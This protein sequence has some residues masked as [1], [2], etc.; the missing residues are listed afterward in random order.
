MEKHFGVGGSDLRLLAPPPSGSQE[1]R[2]EAGLNSGRLEAAVQ[3]VGAD[4]GAAIV[5]RTGA[6]D[7][8]PAMVFGSERVTGLPDFC[9]IRVHQRTP[10]GHVVETVV[11]VPEAWNGRLIAAGGGGNRTAA[12]WQLPSP[13]LR[14]IS[15]A[16]AL[17][18]GFAVATTDAGNRDARLWDWGLDEGS[19]ELDEELIE[20]WA[21]RSTH[22]LAVIAKLVVE[23]LHGAPPKYS[24]FIGSS[25]GGRQ[26][27][28]EAQRFPKDFDGIWAADP[29][30]KWSRFQPVGIW[31]AIVMNDLGTPVPA[32]KQ[33]AFRDAAVSEM[34]GPDNPLGAFIAKIDPVRWD[35]RTLI[36][37][38]TPAGRI[39]ER[40]AEVM[41]KLWEGPADRNGLRLYSGLRPGGRTWGTAMGAELSATAEVD[42][43]LRPILNP[44]TA[45]YLSSWV[46]RDPAWRW[47]TVTVDGFEDLFRL[48]VEQFEFVDADDPDLAAFRDAGG[49]LLISHG[50]D[51]PMLPSMSTVGYYRDVL[52]TM[53]GIEE[54]SGYAR[55]FLSPGDGHTSVTND[56][57]GITLARGLAA[58][59]VWVEEGVAPE[60][61]RG[62][63]YDPDTGELVMTR[64]IYPYPDLAAYDGAGDPA[65]ADCYHPRT[66][67]SASGQDLSEHREAL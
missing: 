10:G 5:N 29:A 67:S 45:A 52:E 30:L 56:G 40:D 48:S 23:A 34:R 4:V 35:P 32:A 12:P 7:A 2:L 15:M 54:V 50:L 11:W 27:L 33:A 57:P 20:N 6:Y 58:L 43:E 46:A 36:G 26:A 61:I 47:D 16:A 22:D 14:V 37:V 13:Y 65:D 59:I 19:S 28:M 9:D 39:T 60:S 51:D 21:Y 42:G 1:P 8:P 64:P 49:K 3:K 41:A 66:D 24:Y 53:G 31:A 25:G 17:K 63:L 18:G 62:E 44:I 55:L 38:D